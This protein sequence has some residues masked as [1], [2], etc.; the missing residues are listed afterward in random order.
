MMQI[1]ITS[2]R[3]K[4]IDITD[5]S[6]LRAEFIRGRGSVVRFKMFSEGGVFKGKIET[7]VTDIGKIEE[8][9]KKSIEN[10]TF[11]ERS[12]IKT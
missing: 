4:Y 12:K 6:S 9:V 10:R 5:S 8:E 3:P 2:I 1:K 11:I 7:K